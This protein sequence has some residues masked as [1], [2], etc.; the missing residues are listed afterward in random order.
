MP[1]SIPAFLGGRER[2]KDDRD[3]PLGATSLPGTRPATLGANLSWLTR[4][5]QAQLPVCGPHAGTHN[6]AIQDQ[7]AGY[8]ATPHYTPRFTTIRM[9][10]PSSSVYDGYPADAGTDMRSLLNTFKA[11]GANTFEPLE[12]DTLLSLADYVSPSAVTP[13]MNAD[14]LTRLISAYAFGNA[15]YDSIAN[16]VWQ[17]KSGIVLIK[18]DEGFWGTSTPT[19]T[20][21][22]YGHFVTAYDY[23]DDKGGIWVLDSAEP[24]NAFAQKFISKEYITDTFFFELGTTVDI[25]PAVQQV[26]SHPT[27]TQAQKLSLAQQILADIAAA[28]SDISKEI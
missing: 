12:N 13:A 18:C 24:N 26:L 16:A 8:A 4:N 15:D 14:A 3:F 20:N 22:T 5:Y 11:V 10:D 9:K 6:K 28:L 1:Q 23:D 27:M 17:W 7:G 21:P 25:P 2:P 19:F